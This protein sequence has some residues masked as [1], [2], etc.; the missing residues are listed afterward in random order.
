MIYVVRDHQGMV[1]RLQCRIRPE[2]KQGGSC[3]RLEGY[4][5]RNDRD[6][7]VGGTGEEESL[8]ERGKITRF[9]ML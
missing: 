3:N 9:Y 5:L 8:N 2:C 4:S 1:W 7:D 6:L